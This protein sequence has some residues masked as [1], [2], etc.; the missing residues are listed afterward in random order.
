MTV[1]TPPRPLAGRRCECR[2]LTLASTV[3]RRRRP[4]RAS[5]E[6]ASIDASQIV[7]P[8]LA[9]RRLDSTRP[10]RARAMNQSM[11][12]SAGLLRDA[13]ARLPPVRSRRPTDDAFAGLARVTRRDGRTETFR[14]RS[15]SRARRS[16]GRR[17]GGSPLGVDFNA[18]LHISA[19]AVLVLDR[20]GGEDSRR[21]TTRG[22]PVDRRIT[23]VPFLA[24]KVH[25]GYF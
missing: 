3:R 1:Q 16:V 24:G 11:N 4:S 20:V 21:V 18:V 10:R 9:T 22:D 2:S 15:R 6:E 19:A 8:P 17:R 25:G 14:S 23:G 12:D 13:S 7:L 5:I